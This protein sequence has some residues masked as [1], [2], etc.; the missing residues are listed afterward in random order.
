MR[1]PGQ[2]G[3]RFFAITAAILAISLA[4]ALALTAVLLGAGCGGTPTVVTSTE[5]APTTTAP[6]YQRQNLAF[7]HGI[8]EPRADAWPDVTGDREQLRADGFNI[9]VLGPPV[10]I[11]QRAGGRPRVIL[12]GSAQSVPGLAEEI[13]NSGLSVFIAPTTAAEGY[14]Q[15]IDPSDSTMTHLTEDASHWAQTAEEKQAELFSPLDEYNLALGTDAA[16]KWS[17]AVLPL[18][19]QKYSGPVVAK[20]VPDVSTAPV[21]PGAQHDFEKLDYRGYDYL[22]LDIYPHGETL[23]EALF[24]AQVSEILVRAN[25]IAQRDGLKGVLLEFGAWR[26]GPGTD[27]IDGPVLGEDNQ[28][29]VTG[30]IMKLSMPQTRGFFWRGWTLPGRGAKGHK[31]EDVLREGFSG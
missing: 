21:P 13:H 7:F 25:A 12:Q 15:V 6:P 10:L 2:S 4:S 17:V 5:T 19:K 23:D 8:D 3:N 24:E 31:I 14:S 27:T 30:A 20:V 18:V 29:L 26:E 16:N 22:M 1:F 11:S 28:A 9:V